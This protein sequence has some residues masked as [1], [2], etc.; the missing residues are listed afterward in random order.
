MPMISRLTA[1]LHGLHCNVTC[2]WKVKYGCS[3]NQIIKL[4]QKND[5]ILWIKM[6]KKRQKMSYFMQER[7]YKRVIMKM[8]PKTDCIQGCIIRNVHIY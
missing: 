5:V 2:H 3:T 4:L 8:Q 7:K 1:E 6:V